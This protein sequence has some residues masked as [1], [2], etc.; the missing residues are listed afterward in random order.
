MKY[1]ND[2]INHLSRHN[3][4]Y[5][6]A[7][8]MSMKEQEDGMFSVMREKCPTLI[9]DGVVNEEAFLKAKFRIVYVL[10]EVNGEKDKDWDLRD[11]LCEGAR[12]ETWDNIAR[13]TEG[14]LN[15]ETDRHWSEM[16]DVSKERRK[17]YLKKICA[18]NLKKTSGGCVANNRNINLVAS[19]NQEFLEQQIKIYKPDII[20]CCGTKESFFDFLYEDKKIDRSMTARGIWFRDNGETILISFAHPASRT[21]SCFLYYAL[22][23]AVKDILERR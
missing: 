7:K 22:L 11:F 16:E 18:V 2:T 10:K 15:L 3:N 14:I 12:P 6:G 4:L 20:I 1:I 9:P 8:T 5:K 23:D 13:W 19:E 17:K 21:K